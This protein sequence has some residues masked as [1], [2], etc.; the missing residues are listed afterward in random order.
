MN[1]H[2]ITLTGVHKNK[3]NTLVSYQPNSVG[4]QCK[5]RNKHNLLLNP[6]R[7]TEMKKCPNNYD[8]KP[9]QCVAFCYEVE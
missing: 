4:T 9:L 2:L 6:S 5:Q 3:N 7:I 1:M 8:V